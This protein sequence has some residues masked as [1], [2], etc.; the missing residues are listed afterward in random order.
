MKTILIICI[1]AHA[2]A[3][4]LALVRL[5]KGPSTVDRAIAVDVTA[6]AA[7]G[8]LMAIVAMYNRVELLPLI[9]VFAA[10]GFITSTTVARFVSRDSEAE[11][12]ILT[13][14]E[15]RALDAQQAAIADDD[16]PFHMV[17]GEEDDI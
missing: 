10:T 14:E 6:A 5:E 16:L 11:S 7:I 12:R 15:A 13:W 1:V 2:L 4:A 17:D 9:V 3:L 8:V